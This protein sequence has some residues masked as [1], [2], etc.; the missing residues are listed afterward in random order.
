MKE[1]EV[2]AGEDRFGISKHTLL[3]CKLMLTSEMLRALNQGEAIKVTKNNGTEVLT[4]Y[5]PQLP[6]DDES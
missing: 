6:R 5:A 1:I 3:R 4:V 2:E